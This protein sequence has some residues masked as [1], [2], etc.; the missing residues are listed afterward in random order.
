MT[1]YMVRAGCISVALVASGCATAYRVH[2]ANKNHPVRGVYYS[3][4]RA[5]IT[6]EVPIKQTIF[7]PGRF[8]HL[9][10]VL[11]GIRA[12]TTPGRTFAIGDGVT[13]GQRTEPDPDRVYVVQVRN[14]NPFQA[15]ELEVQLDALGLL[16]KGRAVTEDKTADFVVATV[17]TA[18]SVL[19]KSIGLDALMTP[20]A[21]AADTARAGQALMSTQGLLPGDQGERGLKALRQMQLSTSI[22]HQPPTD[23]ILH[24]WA[25]GLEIDPIH[26]SPKR[27]AAW[28]TERLAEH[29][30]ED[31]AAS[32]VADSLIL[33]L[34]EHRRVAAK[35]SGCVV[36]AV[37]MPLLDSI[38]ATLDTGEQDQ[39]SKIRPK[40]DGSDARGECSAN[41][42]APFASAVQSLYG[43]LGTLAPSDAGS[44]RTLL[45]QVIDKTPAIVLS[46]TPRVVALLTAQDDSFPYC[47][48]QSS[49]QW[50]VAQEKGPSAALARALGIGRSLE[51]YSR[52]IEPY[53]ASALIGSDSTKALYR[54]LET[55][56]AIDLVLRLRDL[57]HSRT[58]VLANWNT[59]SGAEPG[60][61][62]RILQA[63]KAEEEEVVSVFAGTNKVAV[64]K[65][66]YRWRPPQAC[67]A[68][69]MPA[70]CVATGTAISAWVPL[71]EISKSAGLRFEPVKVRGT[72]TCTGIF[73]GTAGILT[74][75]NHPPSSFSA[76]ATHSAFQNLVALRADLPHPTLARAVSNASPKIRK[77]AQGFFYRVPSRLEVGVL[78]ARKRP[79]AADYDLTNATN[80]ERA[81]IAI[82]QLGAVA[83][84]PAKAGSG[85]KSTFDLDL[86]ADTGA[87]KKI[88][89]TTTG[90]SADSVTGL[91][92]AIATVQDA[93]IAAREKEIE[94]LEAE[95]EKNDELALLRREKELLELQQAIEKLRNPV[96]DSGVAA[97]DGSP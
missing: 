8:A 22:T 85:R 71:I 70:G 44:F 90:A 32:L 40:L 46:P 47:V 17:K 66:R 94:R 30:E 77:Q 82:P 12:K 26:C 23:A 53:L 35:G 84:L 16:T 58:E 7:T 2:D 21:S 34:D 91:G 60:T 96:P 41:E 72:S 73:G 83:Q 63:L 57:Q 42:V 68:P 15:R 78:D 87:I 80:L 27:S 93:Q 3:L 62:D 10:P 75:L 1:S 67:D 59:T 20:A 39:L 65:A 92:E 37:L 64:W 25:Y 6:V 11:L 18:A 19:A 69:G 76:P 55:V 4:P 56:V 38:S 95:A 45:E 61:L 49:G 5:E 43:L 89:V 54:A 88:V 97:D 74:L 28:M 48:E 13:L 79:S 81:T 86:H 33:Q 51:V 14:K 36:K 31:L 9:A 50:S 52:D 24:S 29:P